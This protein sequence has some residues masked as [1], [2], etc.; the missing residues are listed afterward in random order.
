M[1]LLTFLIICVVFGI[2]I[3]FK[4]YV[5]MKVFWPLISLAI[6]ILLLVILIG[7]SWIRTIELPS[8][9]VI[10]LGLSPWIVC[11]IL[12]YAFRKKIHRGIDFVVETLNKRL[13]NWI[14]NNFLKDLIAFVLYSFA[15]V[16]GIM[17]FA[18]LVGVTFEI[19]SLVS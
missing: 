19:F 12:G 2:P 13:E 18:L 6:V 3:T 15:G 17:A 4:S 9:H 10:L 1:G 16:L 8:A 14:G 11:G 7:F 5:L